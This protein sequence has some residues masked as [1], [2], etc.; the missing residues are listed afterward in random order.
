MNATCK[1]FLA[2]SL[3]PVSGALA[4]MD[5]AKT[6]GIPP[7]EHYQIILDRKPFGETTPPAPPVTN[8]PVAAIAPFATTLK[9]TF[10][11]E[12]EPGKPYVGLFDTKLNKSYFLHV[13]GEPEEGIALVSADVE[14]EEAVLQRGTEMSTMKLAAPSNTVVAASSSSGGQGR[15]SFD[16]LRRMR[17]NQPQPQTQ[18]QPPPPPPPPAEPKLKGEEL[19]KHL[20]Q[21]NLE[22]I[23]QGLP[24]LPIQLSPEED[25]QLVTEGV[26]PNR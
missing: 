2:V 26:L 10:I 12:K 11:G 20:R 22:A 18:P 4:A 1:H 6:E 23:R 5:L 14:K 17:E 8:V 24:P 13:G 3:V 16:F 25:K 9:M 7:F 15:P 21:Y 19:E